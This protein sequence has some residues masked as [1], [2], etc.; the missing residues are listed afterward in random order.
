M[1]KNRLLL[2]TPDFPPNIG[3]VARYLSGL[4]DHFKD[5]MTVATKAF[6]GYKEFDAKLEYKIYRFNLQSKW[7]WPKWWKTVS[8]LKKFSHTYDMLV[9]SHVLPFGTAARIAKKTT[10]KPYILILHGMDVRLAQRSAWKTGLAKKVIQDAHLVVVNSQALA[11]EVSSV[12]ARN[13][14]LVVYPSVESAIEI[15]IKQNESKRIISVSRLVARKGHT[16]VI[17]ALAQIKGLGKL[18]GVEYHIV[19]S[20]PMLETLKDM[21]ENMELT[22]YVVF[23]T[24]ATDEQRDKLLEQSDLFVLPII[25]DKTDKEG[26]G[27]CFMEAA[28]MGVPSISTNIPGVDEAIVHNQTG[29][30]IDDGDQQKL[31]SG[32]VQMLENDEWRIRLGKQAFERVNQQFTKDTQY[33]KLDPYV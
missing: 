32:I 12:F 15:P 21:V 13:D 18:K 16:R 30:L 17:N 20:G 1:E 26:F 19:G 33:K 4:A 9:I 25:D 29:L 8:F 7:L 11:R 5:Q 14:A 27:I 10:G 28:R 2:V 23:H 24:D 31:A 6:K 3:G 22:S